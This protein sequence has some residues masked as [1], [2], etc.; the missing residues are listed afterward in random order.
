MRR[1]VC[2]GMGVVSPIGCGVPAFFE[3]LRQA[4][5]GIGLIRGFDA[6]AF[7]VRIA[8]EVRDVDPSRV[9]VSRGPYGPAIARDRKSAFG[10]VAARE[11][12]R[13]AGPPDVHAD[14]YGTFFGVGL[15][16][17]HVQDLIA[18]VR[19]GQLDFEG[20]CRTMADYPV[21]ARLQI[22]SHLGAMEVAREAGAKGPLS[23]NVSACAASTQAV[24]D[25]FHAIRDGSIDAAIVGGYDSMV[26]PLGLGGFC[27]LQ[28]LSTRNDLGAGASRPFDAG[29]DGFV[30]GEGAAALVLETLEGARRRGAAIIGEI[31]GYASTLDAYR[32]T[33]PAPLDA[34]AA[35]AMRRAL[36]DARL[37]PD[38]IDY[39]NAHGTGTP[40]N[41]PAETH[42]IRDVFGAHA[43]AIPV[44]S[45]KSQIGHLIGAAGAVEL[46]AG[47]FAVREGMV[48]ATINLERPDPQCDL[49]YVPN[50]P[51][52]WSVR[53]FVSNSF[54]FGGQ[55]AVLVAGACVEGEP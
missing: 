28:A 55:N 15:E 37:R 1:V 22:P 20:V 9:E 18:H 5:P 6:S 12:L 34:G 44:S 47:L 45:T 27:M 31:S 53:R 16:V 51:R 42:A 17:F 13:E 11:A 25:A 43:F 23:V 3:G 50:H 38:Q 24:G 46:V 40:K 36:A 19:D 48:P 39:I 49:D 52:P 7:P 32:V 41:D 10:L 35:E 33:D 21:H 26:N 4:R 2:T 29:R 30:L 54:G 8:G 14:R